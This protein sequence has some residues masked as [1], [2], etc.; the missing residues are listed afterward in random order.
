MSRTRPLS[1]AGSELVFRTEILLTQ[2]T[3]VLNVDGDSIDGDA[4]RSLRLL[5]FDLQLSTSRLV[6]V[7]T[8]LKL[9]VEQAWQS[10]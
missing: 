4:I 8:P 6:I 2:P 7:Q 9:E 3:N 5:N 10:Q 1:V